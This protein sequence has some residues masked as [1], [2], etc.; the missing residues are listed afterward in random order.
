MVGSMASQ[1]VYQGD[2][3]SVDWFL[4]TEG[5][6]INVVDA[7]I[8]YSLD[9]LQV[10]ENSTGNSGIILWVSEPTVDTRAGTISFSG[11]IPGGIS[12]NHIP[13]LRTTFRAK[14]MGNAT[15]S[16]TNLTYVLEN[17]GSGSKLEIKTV[18]LSFA[19]LSPKSKLYNI[20]SSTHP[21]QGK[22]YTNNDV[23][24]SVDAKSGELYKYSFDTNPNMIPN[25]KEVPIDGPLEYKNLDDGIYYFKL[26]LSVGDKLE[27]AGSYRVQI[28]KASPVFLSTTVDKNYSISNGEPFLSFVASDKMSGITDYKVKIGWFGFYKNAQSPY[29]LSRPIFGN[30]VKVKAID[31]AGNSITQSVY[32]RGYISSPMQF[33]IFF[34]IFILLSISIKRFYLVK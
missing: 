23:L 9:T 30:S 25:T 11:G 8:Q 14:T 10:V 24:I 26:A 15:I 5:K 31:K 32:Y 4:D 22:W 17:N 3:F 2:T 20:T 33:I 28:D 18:P 12:G 21:D 6:S 13:I 27:E 7:N 19:I 34:L 29:K 16:P 1:S